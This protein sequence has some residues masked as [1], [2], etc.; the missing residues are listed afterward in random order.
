MTARELVI[1]HS[2]LTYTETPAGPEEATTGRLVI[3]AGPLILTAI[4]PSRSGPIV[5]SL[6]LANWLAANWFRIRL[7]TRPNHDPDLDWWQ[8][9]CMQEAAN[10]YQWPNI[11]LWASENGEMLVTSEATPDMTNTTYA[12]A[13]DGKPI[14]ITRE[15]FERT[16]TALIEETLAHLERANTTSS[17]PP[18]PVQRPE[19][20]VR[21]PRTPRPAGRR[22]PPGR[23]PALRVRLPGKHQKAQLG[24]GRPQR[25]QRTRPQG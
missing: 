1:N 14:E 21:R 7:E 13:N 16:A 25:L 24:H 9:H 3:H 6:H 10:G 2:L 11:T 4:K 5:S 8:S 23:G 20:R 12:G 18:Q 15:S 17:D 22:S 19:G